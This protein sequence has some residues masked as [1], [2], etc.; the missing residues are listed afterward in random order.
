MPVR[1]GA[2]VAA[3]PDVGAV[4]DLRVSPEGTIG[5]ADESQAGELGKALIKVGDSFT[6]PTPEAAANV[7]AE[8][9]APPAPAAPVFIQ[10]AL[11]K[12][13]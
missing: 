1:V 5:Y 4:S 6:G 13:L 9:W 7:L 11:R 12:S 2:G 3:Q 10:Q 8:R